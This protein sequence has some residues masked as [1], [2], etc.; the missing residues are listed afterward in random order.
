[1]IGMM[2]VIFI[3]IDMK[4]MQQKILYVISSFNLFKKA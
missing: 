3:Y 2:K 1:M 4:F